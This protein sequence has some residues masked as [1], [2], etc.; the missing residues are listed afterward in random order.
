MVD[1]QLKLVSMS[2]AAMAPKRP[3]PFIID[4]VEIILTS[5]EYR[6]IRM[7]LLLVDRGRQRARLRRYQFQVTLRW[8]LLSRRLVRSIGDG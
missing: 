8:A 1:L 4:D 3:P 5:M 7:M 2:M 6:W